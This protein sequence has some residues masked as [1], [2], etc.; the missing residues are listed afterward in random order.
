[1]QVSVIQ[2]QWPHIR[3]CIVTTFKLLRLFGLNDHSLRA[4]NAIIPLAFYLYRQSFQDKPLYL[5]INNINQLR[6]ERLALSR[7]L[8][9]VLLRGVFGGQAD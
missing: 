6:D 3:S 9:M 7:W 8:H 5:S 4:K 2:T 1:D